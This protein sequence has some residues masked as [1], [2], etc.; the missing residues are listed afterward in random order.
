MIAVRQPIHFGVTPAWTIRTVPGAED[1]V[2]ALVQ[3]GP[4]VF[5]ASDPDGS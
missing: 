2:M 4:R 1:R 5:P 3:E